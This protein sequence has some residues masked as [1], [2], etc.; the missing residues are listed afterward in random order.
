MI[1]NAKISNRICVALSRAKMG[2][3]CIGNMTVLQTSPLWEKIATYL[4]KSQ[5]LGKSLKLVCQNHPGT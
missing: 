4:K 3:F 1:K 5:C 2:F